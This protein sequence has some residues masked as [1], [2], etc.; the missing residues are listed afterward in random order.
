MSGRVH[1]LFQ[2]ISDTLSVV[3]HALVCIL[4]ARP[5]SGFGSSPLTPSMGKS[6]VEVGAGATGTGVS[7]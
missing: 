3:D 2:S 5:G 7:G 4:L 6:G 1:R